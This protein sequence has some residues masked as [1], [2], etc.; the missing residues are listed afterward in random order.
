[1][2]AVKRETIR[3]EILS[4]VDSLIEGWNRESTE[5]TTRQWH[6]YFLRPNQSR[7]VGR[8]KLASNAPGRG[9]IRTCNV[10]VNAMWSE[11]L[12]RWFALN[13]FVRCPALRGP[14]EN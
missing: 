13:R 10:H 11:E 3:S 4:E 1:M 5:D 6:L 9:W 12:V 14:I 2:K 8:L 7:R